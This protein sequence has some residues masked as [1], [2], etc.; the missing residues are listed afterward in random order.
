MIIVLGI[1]AV[2]TALTGTAVQRARAAA[3]KSGCQN[4]LRQL[5]LALHSFHDTRGWFPPGHRS[6][7]A[8]PPVMVGSG[9]TLDILPYIDQKPLW[10]LALAAYEETPYPYLVPPH[11]PVKTIVKTFGCPGDSRTDQIQSIELSQVAL[12]SYLG[13]SGISGLDKTGVLFADSKIRISDIL[14]GT[15]NTLLLGERPPSSDFR[16]GGWYVVHGNPHDI[17]V[18]SLHMGV[19]V[20][21]PWQFYAPATEIPTCAYNPGVSLFQPGSTDDKCSMF[22]FW[23]THSGG[24]QFAFCDGSVRFL[25][26][27]SANNI[28]Y[29][30]TRAGGEKQ[31]L[32]D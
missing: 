27:Y 21:A 8:K 32:Y 30:A 20:Q 10:Q 17:N 14:D 2:I 6:L 7:Q 9:W 1:L 15:T 28:P 24:A 18:F 5:G 26:Y 22:H 31:N 16:Y 23:S 12:N 11:T 25:P 29:S 4:N 3:F 13:V 19:A